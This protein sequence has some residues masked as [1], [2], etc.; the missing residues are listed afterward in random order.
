MRVILSAPLPSPE[1]G[2]EGVPYYSLLTNLGV[3][4]LST[5]CVS[6]FVP[7]NLAFF[8]IMEY[9]LIN[10]IFFV[11]SVVHFPPHHFLCFSFGTLENL[12]NL[13]VIFYIDQ[14]FPFHDILFVLV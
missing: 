11:F 5:T 12:S 10:L 6:V 7:G 3:V 14:N 2:G 8:F 13:H 9:I 4:N 1:G